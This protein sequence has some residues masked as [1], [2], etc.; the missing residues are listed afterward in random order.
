MAKD[1][2]QTFYKIYT[3]PA[4]TKVGVKVQAELGNKG[5]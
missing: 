3:Q 1:I 5:K 2:S 4:L